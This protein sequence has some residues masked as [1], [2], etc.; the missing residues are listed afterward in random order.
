MYAKASILPMKFYHKLLYVYQVGPEIAIV[1]PL[2]L[3][4]VKGI[5]HHIE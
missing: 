4:W 2:C 3:A 1:L 5:E